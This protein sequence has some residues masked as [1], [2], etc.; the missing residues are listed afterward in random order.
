MLT[1]TG[2]GSLGAY[3]GGEGAAINA[4]SQPIALHNSVT[5]YLQAILQAL[6]LQGT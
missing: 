1:V 5:L 2:N 3:A 4:R 6:Q